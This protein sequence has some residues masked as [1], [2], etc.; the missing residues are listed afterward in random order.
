M[1]RM[2]R[3]VQTFQRLILDPPSQIAEKRTPGHGRHT[4]ELAVLPMLL[5]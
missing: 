3:T 2:L 1:S 5:R 4:P